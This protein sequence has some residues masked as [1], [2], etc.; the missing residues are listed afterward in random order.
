MRTSSK[1]ISIT[2]HLR[3]WLNSGDNRTAA[4]HDPMQILLKDRPRDRSRF[5]RIRGSQRRL[6]R[7]AHDAVPAWIL[8]GCNACCFILRHAVGHTVSYTRLFG[9]PAT[10]PR[11]DHVCSSRQPTLGQ[12]PDLLRP[13]TMSPSSWH[14]F[15]VHVRLVALLNLGN[16]RM[17]LFTIFM[18]IYVDDIIVASSS[19]AAT[20][21][22]LKD[23]SHEFA[24][25]DLGD[26]HFFFG[27]EVQKV[28][29]GIVLSQAKYAQDILTRWAWLIALVCPR[30]FL[31]LRKL[32]LKTE[33]ICWVQKIALTIEAW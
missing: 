9:S 18:L 29:N 14:L 12:L 32:L 20:D 6:L 21:A 8:R 16:I 17:A 1:P 24:L 2:A 4:A 5:P 33:I 30:H 7:P 25:K 10:P 23:L 11:R 3:L 26:L 27:I 15:R 19:Q 31:L 28:D 22:L 13:S